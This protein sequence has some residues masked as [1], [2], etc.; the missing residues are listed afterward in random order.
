VSNHVSRL[1]LYGSKVI[2]C[3]SKLILHMFKA[4][5]YG[6]FRVSIHYVLKGDPLQYDSKVILCDSMLILY[7]FRARSTD[8]R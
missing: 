1:I 7:I 8:P 4:R 2:L 6:L 3:D 5:F